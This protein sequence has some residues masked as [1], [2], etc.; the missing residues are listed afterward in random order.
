MSKQVQLIQKKI[1]PLVEKAKTFKISTQEDMEDA[2]EMLSQMNQFGDKIKTEKEKITKPLNEALRAERARWKPLE[3]MYDEGISAIRKA[4][5]AWQTAQKKIADEKTEKIVSR[6]GKGKGKLKAETAVKKMDE[7]DKPE[8][9][10]AT[11]AGMVKFRTVDKFEVE[12]IKKLPAEYLLPNEVA[13]RAAMKK[14]EKIPGVRYYQEEVP[15]N[16]R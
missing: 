11:D 10:I 9:A 15:I 1:N 12:D 4:M 2:T 3:T 7:V 5:T 13:I 6:V 14:G 16:F 8:G